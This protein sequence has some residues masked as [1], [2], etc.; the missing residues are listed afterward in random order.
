MNI[1]AIDHGQ[2]RIGLA[3]VNTDL[4]VVLPY[5]VIKKQETNS[6]I[7]AI[8]DVIKTEKINL[9]VIGLPVHSET[10]AETEHTKTIRAFA[11]EL[12]KNTGIPVEFIDESFTTHEAKEMGGGATLDEK[13]AMIILQDYLGRKS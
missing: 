12:K 7:Q 1:L 4:G 10:R 5:G 3:W 9:L 8:A 6:K 11:A 2:K 13:A